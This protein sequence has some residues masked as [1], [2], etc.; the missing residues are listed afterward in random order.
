MKGLTFLDSYFETINMIIWPRFEVIFDIHLNSITS[1]PIKN[2]KLLEKSLGT[3]FI[4]LRYI[5]KKYH[6]KISK[7][8]YFKDF[9][10]GLYKL[11]TYFEDNKMLLSRIN[12]LKT[13]FYDLIQKSCDDI[14]FEK[15]RNIYLILVFEQNFQKFL[16]FKILILIYF[17]FF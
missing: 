8:I 2:F 10:I 3:K 16:N 4:I 9:S 1:I 7:K 13:Y 15:D 12:R 17:L 5:G 6:S 14:P 11:Y